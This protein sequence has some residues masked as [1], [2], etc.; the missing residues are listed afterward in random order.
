MPKNYCKCKTFYR[1]ILNWNILQDD[2]N[3]GELACLYIVDYT[4]VLL[5]F[6]I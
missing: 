4:S 3:V 1:M 6:K 5:S 2:I